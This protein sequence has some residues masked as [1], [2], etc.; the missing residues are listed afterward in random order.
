MP[1]TPQSQGA[2]EGGGLWQLLPPLHNS[3]RKMYLVHGAPPPAPGWL[4]GPRSYVTM[5]HTWSTHHAWWIV[6]AS[7]CFP[8]KHCYP[9]GGPRAQRPCQVP[10][11]H[12]L[13]LQGLALALARQPSVD[14]CKTMRGA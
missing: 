2:Q 1:S 9:E 10:G 14:P 4:P 11:L 5:L 13:L 12:V 6:Y 8:K 3:S 7:Q